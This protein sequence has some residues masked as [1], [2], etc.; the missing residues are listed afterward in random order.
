MAATREVVAATDYTAKGRVPSNG[1]KFQGDGWTLEISQDD[2][3]G[4]GIMA[5]IGGEALMCD[6]GDLTVY[7]L[8]TC[9]YCF[10]SFTSYDRRD[11]HE[12]NCVE[13]G[14]S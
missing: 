11:E 12:P 5:R 10:D 1:I 3:R 8:P 2:G 13:R 6:L 7:V 9:R 4:W 14:A